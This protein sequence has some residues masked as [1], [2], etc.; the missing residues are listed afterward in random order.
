MIIMQEG[1]LLKSWEQENIKIERQIKNLEREKKPDNQCPF[2]PSLAAYVH[3]ASV[4]TS[5]Y[6][7]FQCKPA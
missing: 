1:N 7:L 4:S 6:P 5:Y 3:V 2:F